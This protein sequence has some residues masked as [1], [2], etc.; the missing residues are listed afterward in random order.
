MVQERSIGKFHHW[1]LPKGRYRETYKEENR[2]PNP[3]QQ[4]LRQNELLDDLDT[5][6]NDSNVDLEELERIISREE[7]LT[8]QA[9]QHIE[10]NGSANIP[11]RIHD[12]A[13]DLYNRK[14]QMLRPILKKMRKLGKTTKY[15]H[16]ELTR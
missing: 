11:K 12:E 1:V 13:K 5:V 6:L 2:K 8:K 4:D 15:S 14:D 9:L 3:T 16:D 7:I 10:D